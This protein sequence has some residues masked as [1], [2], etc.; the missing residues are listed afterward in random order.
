MSVRRLFVFIFTIALFTM[1]VRETL[2]PDMW[3]HL[4]TGE[5]ILN[6]GIPQ[7]DVFSFTVTDYAWVTHEWL[8]QVIMWG[9]YLAGGLPGL[10]VVFALLIALTFWLIYAVSAGRPY[11]PAFVTLLSA[12]ASAIVW[13][14][15]PQIFNMLL[16][17]VF[18][19]IIER[20]RQRRVGP[21]VLWLLPIFMVVWANLHSGYL[22]GV[23]LLGTYAVGWGLERWLGSGEDVPTWTDVRR[24]GVV[25]AVS[26]LAAALNPSG[27]EL[28][29]YP[30]L[31]LGSTAMQVYI[32]EWHSPDF[33]QVY[34]W[35]F[36]VLLIVGI[37]SWVFSRKRPSITDLLLFLGTGFAGLLSARHIP[38]FAIVAVPIVS[39]HLVLSLRETSLN[40]LVSDAE[41]VP[42]RKAVLTVLNWIILAAALFT[43]FVW[44][45]NKIINNEMEIARRYPVTAVDYLEESGLADEHGYNSYNWGGYLIWRRLP[46]FV[47]GR[48]DVYGDEFLFY[49][50]QAFEVR[51]NWAEPLTDFDVSYVL[52][53][54]GSPLISLLLAG[55]EWQEVYQDDVAQIVVRRDD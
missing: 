54:R 16:T 36:A 11:L 26:F 33:H 45:T 19:F 5:Y 53:E 48:A 52:M 14:A 42:S 4:R 27:P 21:R 6:N 43:A 22:L 29:I 7:Q 3:W 25:T 37:L 18:V 15:R 10:M 9:I 47:D 12:F 24:L 13:G 32:Q 28:W 55:G 39:R 8:S 44:T 34:F 41:D 30:F 50:L 35:P 49:Y 1:A 23:A 2:D 46:V 40:L 20:Y 38:L 17:A 31:T 51:Q